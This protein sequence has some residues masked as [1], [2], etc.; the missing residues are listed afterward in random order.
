MAISIQKDL[1]ARASIHEQNFI[2]LIGGGDLAEYALSIIKSEN[3]YELLAICDDKY[4]HLFSDNG[5]FFGPIDNIVENLKILDNVFFCITI[6]APEHRR[7]IVDRLQLLE[8]K[9]TNIIH[10]TAVVDTTATLG[11]G[12]ILGPNTIIGAKACIHSYTCVISAIVEHHTIVDYYSTIA[13]GATICGGVSIGALCYI[14]AN[15]TII[16]YK[17][18]GANTIIGAHSLVLKDIP[19]CVTCYGVP[20]KIKKV[21]VSKIML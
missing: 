16:Q 17:N 7:K 3:K 15:A 10:P 1:L 4:E 6:G 18:I 2:V 13:P 5:L 21:N 11:N 14:G 12:I 19:P 8:S 20:A 9:Y